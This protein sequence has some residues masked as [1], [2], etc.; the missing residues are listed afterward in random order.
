MIEELLRLR[1]ATLCCET[2]DEAKTLIPSI[3]DKVSDDDLQNALDD[4]G[5]LRQYVE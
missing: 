5:K 3:A 1:L 2:A 4:I